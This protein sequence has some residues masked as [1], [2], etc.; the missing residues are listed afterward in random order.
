MAK[1]LLKQ[2]AVHCSKTNNEEYNAV[3]YPA[4]QDATQTGSVEVV[5]YITEIKYDEYTIEK[6][7]TFQNK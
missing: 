2:K 3:E 1:R 7:N 4:V 5:S 6:K